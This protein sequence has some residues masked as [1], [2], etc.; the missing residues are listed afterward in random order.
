MIFSEMLTTMR[1]VARH[2][3]SLLAKG[4]VY[5]LPKRKALKKPN[6]GDRV[7]TDAITFARDKV[8]HHYSA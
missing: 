5:P 7:S 3:R 2:E 6:I 8:V 4:F 1:N